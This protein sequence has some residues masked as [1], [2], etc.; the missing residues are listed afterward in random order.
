MSLLAVVFDFDGV[1]AD[2]EPLHYEVFRMV[3]ARHGVDLDR[4]E[5]YARYLGYDDAGAFRAVFEDRGREMS[6]PEIE[7]LVQEKLEL[8]PSVL[9]GR[10]VLFP[11]AESCVHRLAD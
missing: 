1:L 11:G 6:G 5:Y 9:D 10:Q 3:L 8:F 2:S 7:R 4:D